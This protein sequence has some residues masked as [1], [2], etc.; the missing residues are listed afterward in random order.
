MLVKYG[1]NDSGET[2]KGKT[3]DFSKRATEEVEPNANFD[4]NG[5]KIDQS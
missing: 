4:H 5:V 2:R 1:S 3:L